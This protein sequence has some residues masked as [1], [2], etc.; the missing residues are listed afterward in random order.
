MVRLVARGLSNP[1]IGALLR[2][3]PHTVRNHLASVFR[4]ASVSSR[5]ELVF[6]MNAPAVLGEGA[7]RTR[8]TQSAA[9]RAFLEHGP[10]LRGF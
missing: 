2:V 5:A 10:T 6:A 1:E 8:R 9:W 4:K 3:S 7:E